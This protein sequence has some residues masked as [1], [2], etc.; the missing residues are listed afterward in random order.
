MEITQRNRLVEENLGLIGVALKKS[1]VLHLLHRVGGIDDAKQICAVTLM[2]AAKNFDSSRGIKFSTYAV[3]SI[4]REI[5]R[6]INAGGVIHVPDAVFMRGDESMKESAKRA[7]TTKSLSPDFDALDHTPTRFFD[8]N[9]DVRKAVAKL[10]YDYRTIIRL[11]FFE[12]TPHYEICSLLKIKF[13]TYRALRLD[14]LRM[15]RQLLAERSV[16]YAA[17]TG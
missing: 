4:V 10:P 2:K 9:E 11:S 6:H 14:A 16:E 5:R 3:H 7:H 15:L 1:G 17:R 13:G 12:D 8:D